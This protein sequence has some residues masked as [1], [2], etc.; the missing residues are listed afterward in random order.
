MNKTTL[1]YF[2]IEDNYF[3]FTRTNYFDDNTK[4]IERAKAEKEL[5]RLQAINTN[6]HL[7]I[8]TRYDVITMQEEGESLLFFV[9]SE[10][11]KWSGV[12]TIIAH[13]QPTCQEKKCKKIKKIFFL[14]Q[15]KDLIKN[16]SKLYQSIE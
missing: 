6:R 7:K 12:R 13:Y 5:A 10:S 15:V 3:V 1:A 2:T 16:A 14:K 4:S 11:N 9:R 8:V